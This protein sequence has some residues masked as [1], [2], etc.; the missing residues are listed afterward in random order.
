MRSERLS[1]FACVCAVQP[2][3]IARSLASICCFRN[4]ASC[5]VN[6]GAVSITTMTLQCT[7][8]HTESLY[9][10][11]HKFADLSATPGFR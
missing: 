8:A 4:T 1:D 11:Y 2:R 3:Q 10:F 9:S 6:F 5:A 7:L